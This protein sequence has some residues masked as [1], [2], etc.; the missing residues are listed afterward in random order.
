MD[1]AATF[2]TGHNNI[3]DSAEVTN[4]NNSG[5]NVERYHYT[6]GDGDTAVSVFKVIN[7]DHIWFDFDIDGV[8]ATRYIWDFLSQYEQDGLR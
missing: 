4:I 1:N 8:A 6:G 2:W 3:T 5:F 7:G